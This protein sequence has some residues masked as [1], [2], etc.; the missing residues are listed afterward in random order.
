MSGCARLIAG[1][2]VTAET[3]VWVPRGMTAWAKAAEVPGSMFGA[4][5]PP[6][7]VGRVD[8]GAVAGRRRCRRALV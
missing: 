5:R 6:V 7:H 8:R 3:L 1:G 2:A 4:P